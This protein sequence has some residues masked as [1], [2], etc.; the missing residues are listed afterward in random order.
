MA[1]KQAT[2]LAEKL[3]GLSWPKHVT[4]VCHVSPFFAIKRLKIKNFKRDF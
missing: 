3:T 4:G 1:C 2:K